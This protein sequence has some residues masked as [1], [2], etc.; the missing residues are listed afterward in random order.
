MDFV[1]WTLLTALIVVTGYIALALLVA[2]L[3]LD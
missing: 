3:S 1:R 2:E